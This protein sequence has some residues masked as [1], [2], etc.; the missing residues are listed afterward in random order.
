MEKSEIN[1]A[2]Q[3]SSSHIQSNYTVLSV[4][5]NTAQRAKERQR[6]L[7]NTTRE[8]GARSDERDAKCDCGCEGENSERV[9]VY[10]SE[11]ARTARK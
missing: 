6:E 10:E 7:K 9:S 8:T 11:R 4:T 1:T 3:R 2:Q 5:V